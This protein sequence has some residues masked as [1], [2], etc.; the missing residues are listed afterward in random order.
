MREI[1]IDGVLAG[2]GYGGYE[3]SCGYDKC[4]STNADGSFVDF[5][6]LIEQDACCMVHTAKAVSVEAGGG[7]F[8]VR[9]KSTETL[10]DA[11]LTW[12]NGCEDVLD[13]SSAGT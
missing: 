7:K 4:F 8:S 11:S 12:N 10:A 13:V 3:A 2:Y 9:S 5:K 1:V 6:P